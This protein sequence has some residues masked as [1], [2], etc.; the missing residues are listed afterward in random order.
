M[1]RREKQPLFTGFGGDLER[2]IRD[3]FVQGPASI[4]R[5]GLWS[6]PTDVFDA[7]DA[8]VVRMEIPGIRIEETHV[9][10]VDDRLIIRG[11]RGEDPGVCRTCYH[12]MEIHYGAFL[13][14]VPLNFPFDRD[15]VRATYRDG[16]LSVELPRREERPA[17]SH[18]IRI[19]VRVGGEK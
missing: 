9:T 14:I 17:E 7:G 12:Q 10:V 3:F 4:G 2:V 8:V 18:A 11:H 13:K 5:E 1:A 15:G 16:F 6:P 19:Q